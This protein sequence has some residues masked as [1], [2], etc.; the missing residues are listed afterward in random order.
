[1]ETIQLV[2]IGF[3]LVA[4]AASTGSIVFAVI[5]QSNRKHRLEKAERA[6]RDRNVKLLR[7][8]REIEI[9]RELAG[10]LKEKL[11]GVDVTSQP[12]IGAALKPIHDDM[13]HTLE[14]VTKGRVPT[15]EELERITSVVI[16]PD[17]FAEG[18]ST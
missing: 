18:E 15:L 9:W 3:S 7:A 8:D 17:S 4:I 16:D 2:T 12:W 11:A 6:L 13:L 5:M 10:I 1:M 14:L